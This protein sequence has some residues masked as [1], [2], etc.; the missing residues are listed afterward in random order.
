VTVAGSLV[1]AVLFC[2]AAQQ[3][4]DAGRVIDIVFPLVSLVLSAA[5]SVM[6]LALPGRAGAAR[7][8]DAAGSA[9]GAARA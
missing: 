4:F 5:A 2:V 6:M 8:G 1:A 9:P 7:T 3:T